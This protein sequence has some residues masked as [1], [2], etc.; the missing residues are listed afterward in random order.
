[1]ADAV[2]RRRS[3][4]PPPLGPRNEAAHPTTHTHALPR[5]VR[6]MV[7]VLTFMVVTLAVTVGVLAGWVVTLRDQRVHQQ[8]EQQRQIDVTFCS[9]LAELPADAPPLQRIRAE[10][11]C[12]TAQPGAPAGGLNP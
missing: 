6:V 11:H 10:L 2:D 12:D 3:P 5:L 7:A 1:M 9:V 8:A 4:W